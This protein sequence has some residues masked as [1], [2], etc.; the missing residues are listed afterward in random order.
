M[1]E[2]GL[3]EKLQWHGWGISSARTS[4]SAALIQLLETRSKLFVL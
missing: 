3:V 2:L 4:A 1:K